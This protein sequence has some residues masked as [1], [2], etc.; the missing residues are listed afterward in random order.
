[1]ERK[2]MIC[3]RWMRRLNLR[4]PW[5]FMICFRTRY[6]TLFSS[7][8]LRDR[9]RR[10]VSS[11]PINTLILQSSPQGKRVVQIALQLLFMNWRTWSN[12][13]NTEWSIQTVLWVCR[14]LSITLALWMWNPISDWMR[15]DSWCSLRMENRRKRKRKLWC[16]PLSPYRRVREQRDW[17]IWRLPTLSKKAFWISGYP[18]R[19]TEPWQCICL[20]SHADTRQ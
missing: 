13:E 3:P 20:W 9:W 10:M 5:S 18:E 19:M 17:K 7:W 14:T 1:M 4:I 11:I 6:R 2:Y 15:T 12:G 16:G 8:W